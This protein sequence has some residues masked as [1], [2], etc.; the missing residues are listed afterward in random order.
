MRNGK[1]S[2]GHENMPGD[3]TGIC[4]GLRWE[5]PG[6]PQDLGEGHRGWRVM[7]AEQLPASLVEPWRPQ[8]GVGIVMQGSGF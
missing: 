7:R 8:T 6:P 4:E 5:D 3:E 1:K 2:K